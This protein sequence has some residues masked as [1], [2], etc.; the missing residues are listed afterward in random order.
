MHAKLRCP[1]ILKKKVISR[2]TV[3]ITNTAVMC[4]LLRAVNIVLYQFIVISCSDE[5]PYNVSSLAVVDVGFHLLVVKD[6]GI[7]HRYIL[8]VI[9]ETHF[10]IVVIQ[11]C[12]RVELLKYN[13]HGH[14]IR[15][16]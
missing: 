6:S 16:N 1:S 11:R 14:R 3:L 7:Y 4:N 13:C 2:S 10:P 9:N 15:L 5:H 8:S 12:G